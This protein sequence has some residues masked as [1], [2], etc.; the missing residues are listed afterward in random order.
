VVVVSAAAL[1]VEKRR[2]EGK[3]GQCPKLKR[4]VE[5]YKFRRRG[6]DAN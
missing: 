2:R 1:S 5:E 6:L 3:E 4:K